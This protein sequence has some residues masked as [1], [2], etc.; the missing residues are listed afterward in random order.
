MEKVKLNVLGITSSQ[1]QAGAYAL[2]LS[3]EGGAY[4]IPVIV[5]VAEAQSIAV[6]LENVRPPR[7]LS[8]DLIVSLT[9]AFGIGLEEVFIYKFENGVFLSELHFGDDDRKVVIDS[10]TSDAIALAMRTGAPIYTTREI[11]KK[12]GF[13]SEKGEVKVAPVDSELKEIDLKKFAVEELEKMLSKCVEREEYERA[14]EI[15]RI[16]I[17]KKGE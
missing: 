12:A 4:R 10:R 16:I 2:V 5:G 7:P 9:H 8:H 14:A 11:L 17:E 13:V 1:I 15:K 6:K 3:E